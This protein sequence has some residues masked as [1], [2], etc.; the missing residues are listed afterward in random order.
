[1]KSAM[2]YKIPYGKQTIDDFDLNA[3]IETLESDFLTQGPKI[4]E[5]EKKIT[6]YCDAKYAVACSSGTAALHLSYRV[7]N[8]ELK[9]RKVLTTSLSFSATTNAMLCCNLVPDFVDID[10]E[11]Y[12]ISIDE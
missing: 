5:F 12:C 10:S 8:P 2:K 11:N 1:M 6:E 4:I 3:V 7:L 9:K